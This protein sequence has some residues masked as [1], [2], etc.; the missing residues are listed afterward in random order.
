[1]GPLRTHT[2]LFS[3]NPGSSRD[4]NKL[5]LSA[6]PPAPNVPR[7][8]LSSAIIKDVSIGSQ[9]LSPLTEIILGQVYA[10]VPSVYDVLHCLRPIYYFLQQSLHSYSPHVYTMSTIFFTEYSLHSGYPGTS[11]STTP[12]LTITLFVSFND[13]FP[14]NKTF[15]AIFLY[16]INGNCL[17]SIHIIEFGEPTTVFVFTCYTSFNLRVV[18]FFRTCGQQIIYSIS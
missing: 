6:K 3:P 18:R 10:L 11:I 14:Y 13:L 7:F 9:L 1:M 4:E 15:C 17:E 16:K 12:K 5:A 8:S 2:A